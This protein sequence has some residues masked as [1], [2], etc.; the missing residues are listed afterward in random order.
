MKSGFQGGKGRHLSHELH[1]DDVVIG[2]HFVTQP[3]D[4]I[5]FERQGHHLFRIAH[6]GSIDLEFDHAGMLRP[7]R[8]KIKAQIRRRDLL[9]SLISLIARFAFAGGADIRYTGRPSRMPKDT[10]LHKILLIGSGPIVIGQ[11]CEFDYSGVQA[12][13]ALAE[14]GYAVVLVNSNPATIMTDPEFAAAPTS[15]RSRRRRREDHR[16][17]KAGRPPA[18]ARRP[19]GAQCRD[20]ARR[21]RRA[22][23]ATA[24]D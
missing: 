1:V 23:D 16:A 18:H 11:G 4:H 12:C 9:A 5:Q 8:A 15:S 20:G 19:D 6:A 13:K 3:G 21:E 24:R 14:E 2:V 22:R 7:G 17:R 10:S